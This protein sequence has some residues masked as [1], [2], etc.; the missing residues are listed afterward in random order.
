MN[1]NLLFIKHVACQLTGNSLQ[2][3]QEN[4]KINDKESLQQLNEED[5]VEDQEMCCEIVSPRNDRDG[6]SCRTSAI[7]PNE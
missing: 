7:W 5:P 1:E 3:D 4:E 6:V 2:E